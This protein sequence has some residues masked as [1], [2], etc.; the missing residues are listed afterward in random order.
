MLP[1]DEHVP[2]GA[3]A[4]GRAFARAGESLPFVCEGDAVRRSLEQTYAEIGFE[5]SDRFADRRGGHPQLG[6]CSTKA[7]SLGDRKKTLQFGKQTDPDRAR[8]RCRTLVLPAPHHAWN[9]MDSRWPTNYGCR[10]RTGSSTP[11]R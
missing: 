6:R 2:C 1:S 11:S 9:L 5:A 7:V 8:L 3:D 10:N 4:R